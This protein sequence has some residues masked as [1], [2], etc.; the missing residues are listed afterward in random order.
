MQI[1]TLLYKSASHLVRAARKGLQQ[2]F[3]PC[4]RSA[5]QL[6]KEPEFAFSQIGVTTGVLLRPVRDIQLLR[7]SSVV[8]AFLLSRQTRRCNGAHNLE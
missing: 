1:W 7:F 4:S 6:A 2:G 8:R 5:F 3:S